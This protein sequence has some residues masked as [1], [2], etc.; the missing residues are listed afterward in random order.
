MP[1]KLDTGATVLRRLHTGACRNGGRQVKPLG[2]HARATLWRV[3][4][5][6]RRRPHKPYVAK[7][8]IDDATISTKSPARP[9]SGCAA[10]ARARAEALTLCAD[11]RSPLSCNGLTSKPLGQQLH[12]Q[13]ELRPGTLCERGA[14]PAIVCI[15]AC[16]AWSASV[17]PSGGRCS[18]SPQPHR[19][20]CVRRMQLRDTALV[21]RRQLREK[22]ARRADAE[23]GAMAAMGKS[24]L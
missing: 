9:T 13:P 22:R 12:V 7:A 10:T 11:T 14:S 23:H 2:P 6:P 1:E 4:R 24:R 17:M 19:R 16:T 3:G 8:S 5:C 15:A 21:Q 20:P 18:Q